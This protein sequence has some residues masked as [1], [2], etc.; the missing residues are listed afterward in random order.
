VDAVVPLFPVANFTERAWLVIV[1]FPILVFRL[2]AA[3]SPM[4]LPK[5]ATRLEAQEPLSLASSRS[6]SRSMRRK[7]VALTTTQRVL[8][9]VAANNGG[10]S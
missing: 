6:K 8:G 2:D 10:I 1:V 4:S 3:E 9:T 7:G 5:P